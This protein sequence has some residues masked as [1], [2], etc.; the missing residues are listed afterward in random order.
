MDDYK[1]YV[2]S[3]ILKFK[4]SRQTR[5]ANANNT[6]VDYVHVHNQ[7]PVWYLVK[8]FKTKNNIKSRLFKSLSDEQKASW[9]AFY[10]QN[11][12]LALMTVENHKNFHENN[13]FD[14]K[15]AT[16]R[17]TNQQFVEDKKSNDISMS[18]PVKKRVRVKKN[19]TVIVEETKHIEP[20]K[21][22]VRVKK[23]MEE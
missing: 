19:N 17:K 7:I 4:K 15:T 10:D 6:T 1:E 18:E 22:R 8:L 2:T 3:I 11:K 9:L 14:V 16:W 21:K 5:F 13:M 23:N 12:Q 20:V